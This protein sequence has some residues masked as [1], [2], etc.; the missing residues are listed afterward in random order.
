MALDINGYSNVIKTCFPDMVAAKATGNWE[1]KA[2]SDFIVADVKIS[3][4]FS[5]TF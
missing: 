3:Q 1:F 4:K 5:E 2:V